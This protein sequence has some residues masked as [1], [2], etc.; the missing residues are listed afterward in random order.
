MP[1]LTLDTLLSY[2]PPPLVFLTR[3]LHLS[4]PLNLSLFLLL[5]VLLVRVLFPPAPWVPTPYALPSSPSDDY[6]WRPKAHP[7]CRV[8]RR[9]TPSDLAPFDGSDADRPILFA[10]RR[11]VYDVSSGASFY[12]PG[13]PYA[14]FAG[15][16]ASRGLAK[17]SF[18]ADMLS[19][20]D[21]PI[22]PLDDLSKAEWDNL[23]DWERHFQTKYVQCG[24]YV[25][26]Q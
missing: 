14:T 9:F 3:V 12:G 26:P 22:D 23:R 24:D 4:D 19:P 20:L 25:E 11:K 1:T 2:S 13:G 7:P 6:N 21:A 16:D 5:S 8:W 15:R 18:D 17:Q 10:I